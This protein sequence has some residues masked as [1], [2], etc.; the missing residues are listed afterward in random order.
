MGIKIG[1]M[2][3]GVCGTN[4][5]FIYREGCNKVVFVD[6]ADYGDQIFQTM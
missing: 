2:V 3:L 5:Y 1:R 4:C 6:P